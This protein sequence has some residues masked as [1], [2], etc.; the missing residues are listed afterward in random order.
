[1]KPFASGPSRTAQ[2]SAKVQQKQ[3]CYLHTEEK[4]N[5]DA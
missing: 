2:H 1:M 4:L 5:L 3:N